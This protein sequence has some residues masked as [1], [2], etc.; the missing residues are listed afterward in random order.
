MNQFIRHFI[1]DDAWM[2]LTALEMTGVGI[3]FL[4]VALLVLSGIQNFADLWNAT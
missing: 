4:A 3:A 1:V 2:G